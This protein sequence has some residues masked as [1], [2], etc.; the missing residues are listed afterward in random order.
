MSQKAL[1][2]SF[3]SAKIFIRGFRPD[4]GLRRVIVRREILEAVSSSE[5][6]RKGWWSQRDLN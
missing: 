3:E 1:T 2:I 5:E 4:K 6:Q